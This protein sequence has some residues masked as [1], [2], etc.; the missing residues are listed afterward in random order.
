MRIA[1]R[2]VGCWSQGDRQYEVCKARGKVLGSLPI[3]SQGVSYFSLASLLNEDVWGRPC[4]FLET[5]AFSPGL[6]NRSP[7]LLNY[8]CGINKE[9]S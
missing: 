1:V 5:L 3:Y 9:A 6:L 7:G 2:M 8:F 4:E